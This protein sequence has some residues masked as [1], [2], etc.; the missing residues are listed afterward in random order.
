MAAPSNRFHR[1]EQAPP[2]AVCVELWSDGGSV[3]GSVDCPTGGMSGSLI[4]FVPP[5]AGMSA[6]E[7]LAT[8][9]HLANVDE[10]RVVVMDPHDL[11][12]SEW[13]ALD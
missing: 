10:R 5:E 7:A 11:W 1:V 3:R 12:R 2:D 4:P 8:A 9:C 6:E 13:G